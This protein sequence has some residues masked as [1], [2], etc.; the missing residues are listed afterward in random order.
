MYRFLITYGS[1]LHASQL[2]VYCHYLVTR[3]SAV[4]Q[5]HKDEGPRS[6]S[7]ALYGSSQYTDLLTDTSPKVSTKQAKC[8][9]G[10]G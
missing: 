10:S 9:R 8:H 6:P 2:T 1:E 7:Q 4:C 5:L 3:T